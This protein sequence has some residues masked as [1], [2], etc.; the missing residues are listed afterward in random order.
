MPPDRTKVLAI[1]SDLISNER[2][3]I[4]G[5]AIALHARLAAVWTE[6]LTAAGMAPAKPLDAHIVLWL[7]ADLKKV[8]S[9]V[10]KPHEDNYIDAAG[11]IALAS[12]AG[13]L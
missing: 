8:R 6:T 12:E 4:Y 13:G 10:G 1:A 3:A 11:Y 2:A 5:D 7:L 9:L